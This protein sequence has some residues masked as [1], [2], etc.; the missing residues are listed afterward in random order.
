MN[1][2][3]DAATSIFVS[4]NGL[5]QIPEIDYTVSGTTITFIDIPIE[6]S[7]IEIKY[8]GFKQN[9]A[10]YRGSVGYKGSAG[11]AKAIFS[12][13]AP[14]T[15]DDGLLWFDTDNGILNIYYDNEST[16]VGIAE[17]PEGARGYAGSIG[18]QGQLGY[19]GSMGAGY[20]GSAST[21]VGYTGSIGY[22]GS[23][24]PIGYAGSGASGYTGSASTEVGYTGSKGY[25]GSIGYTGS[26]GSGYTGS[27]GITINEPYLSY[28]AS[29]STLILDCTQTRVFNVTP[30]V[31]FGINLT[32]L[33]LSSNYVTNIV[34]VLNQG[35]T[36][37]IPTSL[38]IEGSS[39]TIKWQGGTI[40]VPSANK[41][42]MLSFSILYDGS[43]YSVYGQLIPF[44]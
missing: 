18:S 11:I 39:K 33:N 12:S 24:G 34:L 43:S 5:V 17:G 38:Q 36:A 13:A 22:S 40:P 21:E 14:N 6:E 2:N 26:K 30:Q 27:Q 41:T 42:D 19:T 7:D 8:F 29:S 28:T 44:G 37:R 1:E 31:A 9:V 35:A 10:G 32:N 4:V 23:Q 15:P 20:T 3:V 16:W 25:N